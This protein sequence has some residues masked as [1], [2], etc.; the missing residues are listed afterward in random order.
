MSN[1]KSSDCTYSRRT[2][3]GA[4]A[5]AVTI[6]VARADGDPIP[7]IDTHLH[8]YDPTRPQGVPYPKVPNPPQSLPSQY[9]EDVTPLGITGGIK[10]EASP[11]VEDN[12]W[13]LEI[14]RNEPIIVGMIGN[15]NPTKPEFREYL[16]RYHRN[17]L[18]LGIRYGNVWEGDSL[19]DAVESPDFIA[20][21]KAFAQTG[22]TLEVANPRF[23]LIDAT[24]R[25]TD[26]VPDLRVVLGHL[27]ALPLPTAPAVLKT[28]SDNLRELRRRKVYAKVSG[29]PRPANG[30]SQ[31]DPASYKPMLDFIWDIFGEDFI[32]FAAGWSRMPQQPPP[33]ERMKT[34]LKI[35]QAYV[36]TKGRTAVEKFFWQ[37]SVPAFKW[38][39]RDPKQPQLA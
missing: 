16:D 26:K 27:Q 17:K 15:L 31:S 32:V 30:Q 36:L 20:N 21:M 1:N 11:W 34:N 24:V 10:V 25:L 37:N 12:L 35:F 23:D 3:L 22:L 9:R 6:D 5:A 7:I 8:L 4:A 33:I 18:F 2:F 39:R 29:L 19:V 14:I 38:V 13:V 28:Y